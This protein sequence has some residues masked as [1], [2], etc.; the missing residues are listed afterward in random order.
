MRK[1]L[2]VAPDYQVEFG[3]VGKS[4]EL[5]SS[6]L[7]DQNYSVELV[8]PKNAPRNESLAKRYEIHYLLPDTYSS[9]LV[10]GHHFNYPGKATI[11]RFS[12]LLP[13][14]YK[15]F[16]N[17]GFERLAW[18]QFHWR[19]LNGNR[20][21]AK[22]TQKYGTDDYIFLPSADNLTSSHIL[23][24]VTRNREPS[25]IPHVVLR[26]INV[27]E[28]L[29]FPVLLR[30]KSLFKRL[31]KQQERIGKLI[32]A[33]ETQSQARM[34]SLEGVDAQVIHY[35]PN[36]KPRPNSSNN[37]PNKPIVSTLG[38][39][40]PDKGY[41]KLPEIV[42]R[43][44]TLTSGGEFEFIL[45]NPAKH[46]GF[47]SR[48]TEKVLM[49]TKGVQ[50][51]DGILSDQQLLELLSRTDIN[52]LPYFRDVYENRGS[53]MLYEA[54]DLLIP[55]IAPAGT[56]FGEDVEEYSLGLTFVEFSEIPKL[57]NRLVSLNLQILRENIQRYN[58]ARLQ[59]FR[60][61]FK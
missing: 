21:L 38:S 6:F 37:W 49:A 42:Q 16:I 12:H 15:E 10:P 51:K 53:A 34:L 20:S 29:E 45:Q 50:L 57:I 40:R 31:A 47:N 25:Q 52:L 60:A 59:S 28:N 17:I 33:T 13:A 23:H 55:S 41:E 56:G 1:V 36:P 5:F 2:V 18:F 24:L 8:V 4:L 44:L 9:F 19:E 22:L 35:P 30:K 46:W 27:L 39:A 26:F 58:E 3:H 14:R 7:D 61:I 32:V 48:Q 43:T 54:C 11:Y